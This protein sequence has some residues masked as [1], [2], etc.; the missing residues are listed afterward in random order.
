ML[1]F[2]YRCLGTVMLLGALVAAPAPAAQTSPGALKGGREYELPPW[3]KQS[4]LALRDD[5]K[6]AGAQ[7][8]HAM[9]FMHLKECPYCARL[10]DENFRT[11]ATQ[12]IIQQHFDVIAIDIRGDQT[13]EWLDGNSYTEQEVAQTL[14]VVAT[15][16]VIF[17]DADGK[18]VLKLNGYRR[19][20][21][22]RQALDY[23]RGR[24]YKTQTLASFLEARN[25]KPM[26]RFR[27]HPRFAAMTDFTNF[28]K[29]L[30]VMFEDKHCADCDE[31]H[32]KTLNHPE[33][34]PELAAFT[35]VRLDAYSTQPIVDIDGNK[36][37]PKH[38]AQRLNL[39]Y[40]PGIVLFNEGREQARMDGMLYRFHFKEMLRYVSGKYYEQY[41]S[42][43][44]YNAARRQ[45]LL[46]Q[47]VLI[48]YSQ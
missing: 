21:S 14:R 12:K 43:S 38:W 24:H 4:F 29:P 33:V 20:E 10:L 41:P 32:A 6:E 25:H 37:T 22:F 34:Q 9:L 48:D 1:A 39:S 36:T 13:V 45:E 28:R 35:V 19:P 42:R 11:G 3:F 2:W 18:M 15:P 26:Y 16:T 8:R 47:G 40:R 17:L 30:A 46:K 44:A 5:A 27:A 31:F 23:V 7:G